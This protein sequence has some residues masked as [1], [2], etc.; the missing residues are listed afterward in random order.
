MTKIN[1]SVFNGLTGADKDLIAKA[2]ELINDQRLTTLDAL[3]E[4]LSQG[5]WTVRVA[6]PTD[7][8]NGSPAIYIDSVRG[9]DGKTTKGQIVLRP[10]DLNDP[11]GAN[12]VKLV[13]NLNHEGGGH[14]LASKEAGREAALDALLDTQS[15]FSAAARADNYVKAILDDEINGRYE[16]WQFRVQL[17]S[18]DD[19]YSAGNRGYLLFEDVYKEFGRL[20]GIA[21]ELGLSGA[22]KKAYILEEARDVVGAYQNYLYP[23]ISANYAIEQLWGKNTPAAADY[24]DQVK[25]S[26]N[27]VGFEVSDAV[28]HDDGS[29]SA[30]TIYADGR[31]VD[32]VFDPSGN[33]FQKVE[34]AANDDQV[35]T[36]Y[37]ANGQVS[38]V[39]ETDG[40][41]DNADYATRTTVYDAEGR[42][43]NVTTGM[44]DGSRDWSDNDQANERE[45][46]LWQRR[47]DAQGRDDW[48]RITG[49]DG[50][51]EWFDYDQANERDDKIWSRRY[52]AQGREDWI[53]ITRDD[54]AVESF[55]YDQANE[56][57]DKIWSRRYDAQ[58][59]EDWIKITRDDGA[60]ESFDYDQANE[61]SDQIW[62]R[63][64]DAQGRE[65]WIKITGD[66]GGVEWFDYDQANERGDRIWSNRTDAQGREDWRKITGDDGGIEW[67]D[68]EQAN[69]AGHRIWS[70]YTDAQGREDW[71]RITGD[72]G[73]IEWIDYDQTNAGRHR[74]WSNRTDAQ[75]REDW[76][77]ITGDDGGVES[78]DYDQANER[79][80]R[81]WT[82]YTDAHGRLDW[83]NI[84]RDDGSRVSFD[85]DQDG[86]K[87]W[88]RVETFF[89]TKGTPD[90][91]FVHFDNG[92]RETREYFEGL[93]LVQVPHA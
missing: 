56:R 88:S 63:R 65:D 24:V 18:L 37:F 28:M 93:W 55:D 10:E 64:Y 91:Q 62:S 25:K 83:A 67:I 12:V 40:A 86:S 48:I 78:I 32:V 27:V 45:D 42:V 81:I 41:N 72:D 38:R 82:N 85:Y 43:D 14:G 11:R 60:V 50:A 26:F 47:T 15:G 36:Q 17:L 33:L 7:K 79:G 66:D 5:T 51:V 73:G 2:V 9:K 68:Y 39:V 77:R 35:T 20:D 21:N 75:G 89:D 30:S 16:G 13:D 84:D 49:D 3:R 53:K 31:R 58:G 90:F 57:D 71:I 29:S 22:D 19:K 6:T 4:G 92:V 70:N 61:R 59:R 23:M 8:M 52:D 80:D 76:R 69:V 46:Q 34:T 87:T 1:A 44:D 74:I 54:G